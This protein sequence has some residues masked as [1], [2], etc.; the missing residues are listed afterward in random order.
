MLPELVANDVPDDGSHTSRRVG[1]ERAHLGPESNKLN[2]VPGHSL[3]KPGQ[4]AR[5]VSYSLREPKS[6]LVQF[7]SD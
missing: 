6:A 4:V 2:C 1:P 5:G 3:L 7:R